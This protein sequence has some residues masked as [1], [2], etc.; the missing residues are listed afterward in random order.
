MKVSPTE[1]HTTLQQFG[2]EAFR[3]GQERIIR[4][5]LDG[6][7]VLALLPTGAGK[8]LTYQLTAQ[9]LPGAT[10]VVSPL[11]ALMQDQLD[12]LAA[13]GIPVSVINSTQSRRAA[14]AALEQ[15]RRGRTKLLYV[16]PERFAND[17]FMRTI[18]AMNVSLFV[19]DEAH[20]IS[21]WGHSF[22]PA[23]L[24]LPNAIACMDRP[25]ILA[26][27]A[28]ATPWIRE[29]IAQRLGMRA[30][31][32]VVQGVDRP[33]LFFAVH[34]VEDEAQDRRTLENLLLHAP[35]DDAPA[36][37][38][39]RWQAMQGSGIIYTATTRAAR[40]TAGWLNEWGIAADYYHGQRRKSDRERVQ[41]AFMSGDLR[42]IVAT[43]AFG[44]GIDKPDVRFVIHRDIPG[45]PEAYYQEA[46]RAGRDGARAYCMLIYRPG[47]LGRAAFLSSGGRLDHD[48]VRDAWPH[49]LK[50]ENG[51]RRELREAT[52][53]SKPNFDRLLKALKQ[54]RVI[55]ERR[56]RIRLLQTDIDPE[57]V[58]LE[59]EERRHAYEQSRTDMMRGY[60]ESRD[61]RR[62]Y[63][64]TYFGEDFDGP[65][66][67]CDNCVAGITVRRDAANEPF[68]LN[69]RVMHTAWGGGTVMR[70]EGEKLVVLFDDVGYK[71]LALDLVQEQG[72]LRAA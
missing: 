60:A 28:T 21:E 39:E 50:F 17:E 58:P 16:T 67:R 71:S 37:A 36:H 40:E 38:H 66:G 13:Q 34:R 45:S 43:N 55:S 65:C 12:S 69:S 27:T 46:G 64:L 70:Y 59:D 24:E 48:D 42:V 7:D 72:L 29:E 49:F 56:G 9:L 33:N 4:A 51:T 10:V 47:D 41:N 8:S 25:T 26:L 62:E 3:P 31:E 1:L 30:P 53:L 54:A 68:P 2:H 14:M 5:L 6:H 19:V 20:C 11:I 23:Y 22:R 57:A 44:L 18:C 15:V 32:L 61:C 35:D 63:L 52:G